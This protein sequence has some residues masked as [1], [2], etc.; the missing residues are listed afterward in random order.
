MRSQKAR[1]PPPLAGIAQTR[2]FSSSRI[3][4]KTLKPDDEEIYFNLAVTFTR[5]GKINEALNHY[6]EALRL[7]PDYPEAHNNLGNLLVKLKRPKEAEPHFAQA[8]QIN[9]DNSASYN[10]L[11]RCL[12]ELGRMPAAVT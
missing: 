10:N 5:Q 8:I 11:G 12:V 9:P 4:A 2:F 7:L 3:R 6:G 1:E